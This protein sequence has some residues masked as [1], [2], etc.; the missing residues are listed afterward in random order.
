MT[1]SRADA[2]L[3]GRARERKEVAAG[4]QRSRDNG[5]SAD[6][7]RGRLRR[8]N[9]YRCTPASAWVNQGKQR[10]F[11]VYTNGANEYEQAVLD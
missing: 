10:R 6:E 8:V 3:P 7:R 2:A 11:T 5:A 4:P 9:T 1:W